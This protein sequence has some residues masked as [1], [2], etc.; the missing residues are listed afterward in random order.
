MFHSRIP[1]IF[2]ALMTTASSLFAGFG[3]TS[4]IRVS[5]VISAAHVERAVQVVHARFQSFA[6]ERVNV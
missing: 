3:S 2:L 1:S 5:C 6:E 4:A